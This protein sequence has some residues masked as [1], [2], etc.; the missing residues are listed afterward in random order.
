MLI[1][2]RRKGANPALP[3]TPGAAPYD[4]LTTCTTP[5]Y[6]GSGNVTHPS[7]V[8]MGRKWDGYRY[9]ACSTDGRRPGAAERPWPRGWAH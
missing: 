7:V 6:D 4:Y 2:T 8:D 9:I 3:A 1:S 5:T